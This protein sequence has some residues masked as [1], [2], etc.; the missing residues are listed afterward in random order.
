MGALPEYSSK[1]HS[2]SPTEEQEAQRRAREQA[3]A[4][5]WEDLVSSEAF[6]VVFKW[7]LQ[8]HF[9][10]FDSCFTSDGNPYLAAKRD[11]GKEVI[12]HIW[13]RVEA[14]RLRIASNKPKKKPT[15]TIL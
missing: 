13:K 7:D 12:G 4:E 14:A 3:N 11:G 2:M 5:A 6:D 15:Q 9:P 1:S 8:V 10:P